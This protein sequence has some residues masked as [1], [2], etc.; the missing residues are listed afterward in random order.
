M[1][2]ASVLPEPLPSGSR[3]ASRHSPAH[4]P[5][6]VGSK[7]APHA[8]IRRFRCSFLT[9]LFR[10]LNHKS[11][12]LYISSFSGVATG[13]STPVL[14]S[15]LCPESQPQVHLLL[16]HEASSAFTPLFTE[17]DASTERLGVIAYGL[18]IP[19]LQV[20]IYNILEVRP[21]RPSITHGL[22]IPTLQENKTIVF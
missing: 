19:T 21:A 11:Q 7:C 2:A 8:S 14:Y 1:P 15:P 9:R 5:H 4:A 18:S 3:G 6:A 16:P 22:S 13:L 20:K 10:Y 12:P 17:L